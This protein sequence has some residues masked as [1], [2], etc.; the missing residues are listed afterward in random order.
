MLCHSKFRSIADIKDPLY[1][2]GFL[3]PLLPTNAELER[4][5]VLITLSR[6]SQR[7]GRR[8]F[9]TP[10]LKG[11]EGLKEEHMKEHPPS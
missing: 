9:D 11:F 10:C 2:Y 3:L 4:Q 6:A 7:G 8:G 1:L 5:L